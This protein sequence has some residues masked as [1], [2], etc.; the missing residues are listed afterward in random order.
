MALEWGVPE[1]GAGHSLSQ[2][3][4]VTPRNTL[5]CVVKARFRLDNILPGAS[6]K[7]SGRWL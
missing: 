7:G 6:G 1:S 4:L 5:R 3:Y 2:D